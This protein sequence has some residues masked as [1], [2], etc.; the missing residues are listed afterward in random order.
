VCRAYGYANSGHP[1]AVAHWTAL[2]AAGLA[3]TGDRCPPAGSFVFW[4]TGPGEAGHV[5]LVAS[6]DGTC[7]PHGITVVSNEVLDTVTASSGGVYHVT[8]A[9]LEAGFVDRARYLGWSQPVC[10]G[11]PLPADPVAS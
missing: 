7:N 8:L 5:A 11:L 4:S 6:T 10:A 1:T 3:R 2:V 9:R